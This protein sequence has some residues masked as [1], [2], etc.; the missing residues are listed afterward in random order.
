MV[1]WY[2][3]YGIVL[4]DTDSLIKQKMKIGDV[5]EHTT[6]LGHKKTGMIVYR[7]GNDNI[8]VSFAHYALSLIQHPEMSNKE[9]AA[10]LRNFGADDVFTKSELSSNRRTTHQQ[11]EI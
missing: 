1:D 2:V 5:V 9:R 10:Y 3:R 8:G 6:R 11:N 7:K 4:L